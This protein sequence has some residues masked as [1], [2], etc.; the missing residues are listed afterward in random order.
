[1][2]NLAALDMDLIRHRFRRHLAT[3]VA[4]I[5][6][7]IAPV[8]APSVAPAAVAFTPAFLVVTFLAAFASFLLGRLIG[9]RGFIRVDK[10]ACSREI[11]LVS[12]ARNIGALRPIAIA[13]KGLIAIIAPSTA[14]ATPPPA[15]A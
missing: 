7:A 5:A 13:R 1:M 6:I 12:K 9:C 14:P 15:P 8:A 10:V 11:R 2:A 3:A 4:L